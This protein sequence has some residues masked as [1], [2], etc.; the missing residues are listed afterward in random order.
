MAQHGEKKQKNN[1]FNKKEISQE[2][3]SELIVNIFE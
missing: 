3:Q 2:M 1:K